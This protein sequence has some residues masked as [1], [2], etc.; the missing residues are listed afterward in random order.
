[1]HRQSQR[2]FQF[3]FDQNIAYPY[4]STLYVGKKGIVLIYKHQNPPQMGAIWNQCPNLILS[5]KSALITSDLLSEDMIMQLYDRDYMVLTVAILVYGNSIAH[6]EYL[7][8]T[9][10]DICIT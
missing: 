7:P 9:C 4:I 8:L 5:A 1:M 6:S 3:K 10:H 2:G